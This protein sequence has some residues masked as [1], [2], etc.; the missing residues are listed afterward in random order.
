MENVIAGACSSNANAMTT[1]GTDG[2][3]SSPE[4]GIEYKNVIEYRDVN[5]HARRKI[6]AWLTE[7]RCVSGSLRVSDLYS[8]LPSLA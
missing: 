4:G 2:G 6:E 5:R 8:Y 3:S 7:G 1:G